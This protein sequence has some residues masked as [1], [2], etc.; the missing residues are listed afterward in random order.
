M[1]VRDRHVVVTG[2]SRGIGEALAREF[3]R[4]GARVTVVARSPDSLHRVAAEIGGNAVVADLSDDRVVD[5]LV[6]DI[7]ARHGE[8]DVLVNNAG[9]ETT[10]PFAV[11]DP[12]AVRAV[13]RLNYEVPLMLARQAL[14]GMLARGRGHIVFVSSLAG[15]AGFPGMAVYCGT[16]AGILNFFSSLQREL[17]HAP[18]GLTVLSPVEPPNTESPVSLRSTT[19]RAASSANAIAR[20]TSRLSSFMNRS[21]IDHA[22]SASSSASCS[23]PATSPSVTTTMDHPASSTSSHGCMGKSET[24]STLPSDS[25][26]RA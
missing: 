8:I 21:R 9:L 18:V 25:S 11:E 4:R 17:K 24:V 14:P 22:W 5:A 7:E 6:A 26:R 2:G 15:T 13:S 3:A 23:A 20:L 19:P 1:K 10:L 16:K 12:R